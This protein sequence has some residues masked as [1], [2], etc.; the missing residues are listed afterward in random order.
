MRL[1]TTILAL[2]LA[3]GCRGDDQVPA[4]G[5]DEDLDDD[6]LTNDEELAQGLDPMSADT[7]GDGWSDLE[8]IEGNTSPTDPNDHPN[9]G[10][11]P[12]DDCR[13]DPNPT[14]S[15]TPN[16]AL[17]DQF[18]DTVRLH[19]FCAREVVILSGQVWCPQFGWGQEDLQSWFEDLEESGFMVLT[20][21][22]ET[23]DS[24]P[25]RPDHLVEWVDYYDVTHPVLA[26]PDFEIA[27]RF[28][29][30]RLFASYT[31]IGPDSQLLMAGG[32]QL[33][34]ETVEDNLP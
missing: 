18:G 9:Q 29:E 24:E 14:G 16:F 34:R 5:L 11:W 19:D 28:D 13:W 26:D 15:E 4:F 3:I 6:G 30:N 20:L 12:I 22:S 17:T 27:Y 8:E 1:T 23:F 21:L 31:L 2:A 10:G 25:I 32:S 33:S 7:D